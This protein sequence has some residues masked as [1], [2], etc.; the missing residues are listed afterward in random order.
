M[1]RCREVTRLCA[2]ESVRSAPWRTRI[3]VRVHLLLCR[4]CRRYMWELRRIAEAARVLGRE[5]AD[6]MDRNEDLIDRVLSDS[7]QRPS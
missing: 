1:L 2:S 3:G 4:Y 6:D 5:P 7:N